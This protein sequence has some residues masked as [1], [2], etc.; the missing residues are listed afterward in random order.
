MSDSL[1]CMIYGS[2]GLVLAYSLALITLGL[3]EAARMM[4]RYLRGRHD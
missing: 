3:I 4:R 1:A 2:L